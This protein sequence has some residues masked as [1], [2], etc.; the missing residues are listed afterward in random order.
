MKGDMNIRPFEKPVYVTKPFLTDELL[1]RIRRL[2]R[3][4]R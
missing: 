3:R 1:A 2:L 4:S